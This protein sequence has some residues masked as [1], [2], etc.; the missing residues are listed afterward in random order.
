VKL[1][2]ITDENIKALRDAIEKRDPE[3]ELGRLASKV[4]HAAINKAID[5]AEKANELI[6]KEWSPIIDAANALATSTDGGKIDAAT[7]TARQAAGFELEQRRYRAESRLNQ[8]IG[9]L[10]EIRVKVSSAESDKHRRKS[11]H[12]FYAML[13]AQI[14]ATV[15]ALAL[16]RRTKSSLWFFAGLIGLVSLGIGGYVML[17]Q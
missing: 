9:F 8:G 13:A 3:A 1:P 15:S 10:Y 7:R 17:E 16:A 2:E 11:Q 5:D 6:D 4:S 14:A 12:F